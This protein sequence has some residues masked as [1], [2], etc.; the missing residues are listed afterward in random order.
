MASARYAFF[1]H[2]R[3]TEEWL[4]LARAERRRI[5]ESCL[6]VA[7][8]GTPGLALR[9]FDAEAFT[10]DCS[11][12][13]LAETTDPLLYYDFMERLRDSALLAHPYFVLVRIVPAIEDG[14][15]GFEERD[16]G[17]ATHSTTDVFASPVTLRSR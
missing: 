16:T 13:V 14:Y 5:A 17:C 15:R 6:R 12:V 10:A 8:A 3:A 7:T 4:R 11:D 1:I 2:L 9:H